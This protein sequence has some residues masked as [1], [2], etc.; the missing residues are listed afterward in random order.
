MEEEEKINWIKKLV[1][2]HDSVIIAP[3]ND[4]GIAF[5]VD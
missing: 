2:C 1:K 3:L 5:D 4:S